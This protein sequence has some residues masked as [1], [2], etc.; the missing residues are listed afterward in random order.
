MVRNSAPRFQSGHGA[1]HRIAVDPIRIP[2]DD[3]ALQA[4][5]RANQRALQSIVEHPRLAIDYIASFLGRLTSEEAQ[6]HYERY[7]GP[8]LPSSCGG[9]ARISEFNE[10]GIGHLFD[11]VLHSLDA[12]H[13]G[14]LA[15]DQRNRNSQINRG[16]LELFDPH[17]TTATPQFGPS[18]MTGLGQEHR[19]S[20]CPRRV[21]ST[22]SSGKI[23]AAQRTNVEGQFQT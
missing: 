17:E 1:G 15:A 16:L 23:A 7:I 3:P 12:D 5:V 2:L 9:L 4:L 14:R 21:R 6:Q 10:L 13:V 19:F 8:I 20:R 18:R 11:G 22:S